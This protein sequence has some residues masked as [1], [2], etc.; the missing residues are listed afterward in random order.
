MK[1]EA[2]L[3]SLDL[4]LE[5]LLLGDPGLSDSG[6]R[7]LQY[8]DFAFRRT[9]EILQ[10]PRDERVRRR[11]EARLRL[12]LHLAPLDAI[13]YDSANPTPRWLLVLR[14]LEGRG[15]GGIEI[16]RL[17]RQVAL[18]L[19]SWDR[20]RRGAYTYQSLLIRRDGP[21]CAN[22]HVHFGSGRD[23]Q[24]LLWRD[25]F[26]PYYESPEELLSP[27]VD[28]IQAIS[29]LGTN[30]ISNLQLLCRLC[31]AGK[32]DGLGVDVRGEALYAGREVASI[33]TAHRARMLFYVL[34]RDAQQCVQ[35]ESRDRELTIRPVVSGGGYVRSNL[36]SVCVSCADPPKRS[37]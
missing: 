22:C 9:S 23:V 10:A 6:G 29:A 16:E 21:F 19:D 35:C 24:T 13:S 5:S 37:E 4:L 7:A 31:N 28:H 8:V 15:Y 20:R 25:V 1:D 27:E 18:V 12:A 17:A 3:D 36:Q 33:P 32:G 14:H 11:F 30:E 26:K 34:D 2:Q